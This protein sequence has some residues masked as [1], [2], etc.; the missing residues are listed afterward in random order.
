MSGLFTTKPLDRLLAEAREEG[1]SGLKRVLG[2]MNLI[3]L[4]IGAVIGAGIFVI[5][6]SVAARFAGPSIILS[7][8]L[9]GLGC[10]F[11]GLCYAELASMIPVSGSAYTYAYAS[12]GEFIA[13]II[14]WDLILEYAFSAATVASGLSANF[15]SLLQDFGVPLPPRLIETPGQELYL[16][17]GRWELLTTIAPALKAAGVSADSLP[18]VTAIFN[19]PAFIA[20]CLVTAILVVG[21]KESAN[22]N[23]AVVFVK[24]ITVLIFIVIAAGYLLKNPQVASANWHP[25]IPE[26]TGKFGDFGWSGIARGAASIFFAFIGFDAVSTAAQ[27]ARNPQRDMPI[28]ILGSLAICT[29]LYIA[30]SGLLTGVLHYSQ[31][32]V[33]APVALAIDATGVKWGSLLVKAGT[34]A[35]TATVM[36][37][38]LMGQSRIFFVM[39]KDGMLPAWAGAIHPRFRTPWISSIVVGL[40]IA[41][42]AGLLPISILGDLVNI[43]TLFAFVIVC[44]G[45]W[46]LR[47]KR[48][49]LPRPFKTPLVPVV[50]VMGIVL[51]LLLMAML[52]WDTWMRLIVWLVIGLGIYFAYG[53]KRIRAGAERLEKVKV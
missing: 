37:M 32:N 29:L 51:S 23:V 34:I 20:V 42:F 48:P 12:M 30:V 5:T 24:V 36:L 38:T 6:G 45:V 43:G 19:L 26:N 52:P 28:G 4:G 41:V 10:A 40:L 33:A 2:P 46:I 49:E 7:F 9:A 35:G 16:F 18:H 50:P 17:Q 13:W 44:I 1:Q 53:R 25:F 11:A 39:S 47:K 31:L 15:V 21:V 27:E 3:A 22:L 14:G 8:V